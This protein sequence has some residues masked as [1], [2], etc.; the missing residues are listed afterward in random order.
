MGML[1]Y[2]YIYDED[3]D[4][5]PSVIKDRS[6][7][8]D[9]NAGTFGLKSERWQTQISRER[10]VPFSRGS[11]GT[12]SQ[13]HTHM[14]IYFQIKL[15]VINMQT[16]TCIHMVLPSFIK[17]KM[18]LAR[19]HTRMDLWSLTSTDAILGRERRQPEVKTLPF[20]N[21]VPKVES[22]FTLQNSG[23]KENDF[24]PPATPRALLLLY[25]FSFNL[26][27]NL[28]GKDSLLEARQTFQNHGRKICHSFY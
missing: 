20:Q 1:Q 5:N 10:T 4:L 22:I 6:P 18:L 25:P 8:K 23:R 15:A 12:N 24:F 17:L 28:K 27:N 7:A 26:L 3:L 2:I 19:M 13:D 11:I 16:R 14:F 9:K 21:T